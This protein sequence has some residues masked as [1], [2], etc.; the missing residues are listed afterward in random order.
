MIT[1][2]A[3]PRNLVMINYEVDPSLLERRL[4]RGLE[5]DLWDGKALLSLVG[6]LSLRAS[7]FGLPLGRRFEQVNLRFYVRRVVGGELRRSVF[8][9]K[10]IVARRAVALGARLFYGE[11]CAWMPMRHRISADGSRVEYGWFESGRWNSFGVEADGGPCLPE[12]DSEAEFVV[13]RRWGYSFCRGKLLEYRVERPR[14]RVWLG[15]EG[16]FDCDASRVYGGEFVG[17]F[18][19]APRSTLLV[20]GSPMRVRLSLQQT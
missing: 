11:N 4:P 20:E 12:P 15:G 3:E 14:W 8:F 10:E 5:L 9:I 1:L 16:W 7:V 13:E 18:S 19:S 6:L 2:S 17:A